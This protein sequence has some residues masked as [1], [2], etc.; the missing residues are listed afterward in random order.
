M[1]S[2][3]CRGPTLCLLI[4]HLNTSVGELHVHRFLKEKCEYFFDDD[5]KR[6]HN[7]NALLKFFSVSL[8]KGSYLSTDLAYPTNMP[9]YHATYKVAC[10]SYVPTQQS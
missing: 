3:V 9:C 5:E 1:V 6:S 10:V 4:L 8:L 2:V 7:I